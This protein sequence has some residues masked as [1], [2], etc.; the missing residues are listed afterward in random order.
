MASIYKRGKTWTASVSV[1]DNGKYLK[2]TQSGF[3]TKKAAT[4]W[5]NETE[6]QKQN[7][8]L[9]KDNAIFVEVFEDWYHIFK[10][11][12]LQTAT[13]QWY[14][15]TLSLLTKKWG[16]KKV[17]EVT[18]KDFQL[19]IN[20]Y[21]SEHVKSSVSHI[22]NITS[23]FVR[24][25]ID[26]G[27]IIRDF[28]RNVNT[29]SIVKSKDKSLKFLEEDE[30]KKLIIRASESDAVTSHMILTALYSGLRFSEVAGLTKDDFDFKNN[31]ISVNKSWQ[32]HDQ[33]FKETKT[34]TSNR[35]ITI[36]SEFMNKAK[37]WTFG[38]R[39][40]FQ[41]ENGTPPSDNAANKQLKRFLEKDNST[42][43]TFHGLRHTHASFLL[44]KD[45]SIQYVSER[46]G[47]ADVNITLSTYAHLLEKKRHEETEKAINLFKGLI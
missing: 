36:S 4:N 42:V 20:E 32:I 28:T 12:Q 16:H 5:A 10:E 37:K 6:V 46:L 47:H 43:I 2:K 1:P 41:G 7:R 35:E 29:Y 17:S 3:Q 45:I 38:E 14:R 15:T 19:L 21:G 13:K 25:A 9:T 23:A 34:K 22:K 26:E 39:F 44:S 33:A 31:T 40:A 24:Y 8:E 30:M 18:P 27:L 11:P